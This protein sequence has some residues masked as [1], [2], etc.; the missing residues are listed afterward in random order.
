MTEGDRFGL[1]NRTHQYRL[2]ANLLQKSSAEM[3]LGVLVE[4]KVG[5]EPTVCPGGHSGQLY[6]GVF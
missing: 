4:K 3:D 2:G 6:P 1:N 5:Q